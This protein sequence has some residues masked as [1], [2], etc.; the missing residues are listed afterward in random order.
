[1]YVVYVVCFVCIYIHE[2]CGSFCVGILM[3]IGLFSEILG[4]FSKTSGLFSHT[5]MNECLLCRNIHEC[6]EKRPD[7]SEKRPAVS[8]KRPNVSANVLTVQGY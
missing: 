6:S 5:S 4:L 8:A 7:V 3:S 2:D 1:M